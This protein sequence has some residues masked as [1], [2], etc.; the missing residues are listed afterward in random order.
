L[1]TFLPPAKGT[2]PH[3]RLST[4]SSE[5][6]PG[7]PRKNSGPGGSTNRHITGRVEIIQTRDDAGA[8]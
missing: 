3:G 7:N 6:T 2:P 1:N 8:G 4:Q 5:Q